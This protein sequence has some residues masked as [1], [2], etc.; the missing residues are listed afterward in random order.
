MAAVAVLLRNM[1]KTAVTRMNPNSTYRD[2]V[3]K[4]LSI[5]RANNTSSPLFGCCDGKNKSAYKQ[6]DDRIGKAVHNGLIFNC[7]SQFSCWNILSEE[8]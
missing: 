3:P 1:E 4:G 5:T 7:L 8:P 2:C 6:H